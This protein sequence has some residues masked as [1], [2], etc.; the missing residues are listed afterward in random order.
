VVVGLV[1]ALAVR[2]WFAARALGF[3]IEADGRIV[4]R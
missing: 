1:G 2:Y 3:A 4:A